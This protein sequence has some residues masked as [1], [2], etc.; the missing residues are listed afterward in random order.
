MEAS[1]GTSGS[2][3]VLYSMQSYPAVQAFQRRCLEVWYNTYGANIGALQVYSTDSLDVRQRWNQ[4]FQTPSKCRS[5]CAFLGEFLMQHIKLFRNIAAQRNTAIFS[6]P[7][8]QNIQNQQWQ[9]ARINF[10]AQ[11][12]YIIIQ[13]VRGQGALGDIAIDDVRLNNQPCG[14]SRSKCRN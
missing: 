7:P 3:A 8:N 9:L 5:F 14:V 6:D 10:P 13:G 12:G 4:I 2:T 11:G 1:E